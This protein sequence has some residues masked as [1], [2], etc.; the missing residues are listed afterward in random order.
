MYQES[1]EALCWIPT[2]TEIETN[3]YLNTNVEKM[4]KENSKLFHTC[5]ACCQRNEPMTHFQQSHRKL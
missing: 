1:W 5:M 4:L 3:I 2:C